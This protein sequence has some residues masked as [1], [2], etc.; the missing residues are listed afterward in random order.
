MEIDLFPQLFFS[1]QIEYCIPSLGFKK[2]QEGGRMNE[3]MKMW[4]MCGTNLHEIFPG[5]LQT[6][7]PAEL[8]KFND[9]SSE[10]R[11]VMQN[12]LVL[13][14]SSS[15]RF[16]LTGTKITLDK[17]TTIWRGVGDRKHEM[18]LPEFAPQK[19][20]YSRKSIVSVLLFFVITQIAWVNTI[21]PIIIFSNN[22][23]LLL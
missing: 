18:S 22:V 5:L 16:R 12:R 20:R 15:S 3:R 2:Y 1:N 4:S 11:Y 19:N 21:A 8:R 6:I 17:W 23:T 14:N 7:S 10:G 13:P 9:S